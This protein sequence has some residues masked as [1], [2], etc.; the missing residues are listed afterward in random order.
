M[1][2]PEIAAQMGVTPETLVQEAVAQGATKATAF[3]ILGVL[4]VAV[5]VVGA[6]HNCEVCI[7]PFV[8]FCVFGRM[9]ASYKRSRFNQLENRAGNHGEPVHC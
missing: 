3:V 5:L 4:A 6:I 2:I 8:F 1:N 7:L 9:V